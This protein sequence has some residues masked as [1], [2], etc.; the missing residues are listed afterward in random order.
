MECTNISE[1]ITAHHFQLTINTPSFMTVCD[2]DSNQLFAHNE[3]NTVIEFNQN[4]K[5]Q[6]CLKLLI[7]IYGAKKGRHLL[8]CHFRYSTMD[9][10]LQRTT[11]L[12]RY[13]TVNPFMKMSLFTKD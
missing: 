3:G 13:L 6:Q 7:W 12:S 9:G 11:I 4:I 1:S 10:A 2:L 8:Q 5:P